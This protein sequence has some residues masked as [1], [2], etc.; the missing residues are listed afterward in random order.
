MHSKFAEIDDD[1]CRNLVANWQQVRGKY[2]EL[3]SRP[4][5][6]VTKSKVAAGLEQGLN[7]IPLI[8]ATASP[9]A[10]AAFND[11][12]VGHYPEFLETQLLR[13]R[14]VIERGSIRSER[15]FYLSRHAIDLLEGDSASR[16]MLQQLYELVGRYESR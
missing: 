12:L 11:A 15:E 3:L 9:R 1:Q 8:L 16:S 10:R 6:G 7:E 4:E 13:L 5:T 14:K 2:Y